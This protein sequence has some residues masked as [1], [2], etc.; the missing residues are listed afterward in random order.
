MK[1]TNIIA[2]KD[3]ILSKKVGEDGKLLKSFADTTVWLKETQATTL[4]DVTLKYK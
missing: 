1:H 3:I 4:I 2:T